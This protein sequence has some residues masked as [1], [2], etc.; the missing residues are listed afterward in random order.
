MAA[1]ILTEQPKADCSMN[2]YTFTQQHFNLNY[3]NSIL[4][5]TVCRSSPLAA[6]ARWLKQQLP[7]E[8]LH[9]TGDFVYQV[10]CSTFEKR[11]FSVLIYNLLF[12]VYCT[13]P[14]TQWRGI[15]LQVHCQN[16]QCLAFRKYEEW[17]EMHSTCVKITLKKRNKR[18]CF[19]ALSVFNFPKC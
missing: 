3:C 14:E 8:K 19:I 12:S 6:A 18:T 13:R 17:M 11:T 7:V 1:F 9:L 10:I 4:N 5:I 16:L 2:I 15:Q